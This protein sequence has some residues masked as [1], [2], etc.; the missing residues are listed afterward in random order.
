M[1]QQK[2][3]TLAALKNQIVVVSCHAGL[4][5]LLYNLGTNVAAIT[6]FFLDK[7]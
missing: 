4:L 1:L 3:H 6:S 7:I 2:R 5:S